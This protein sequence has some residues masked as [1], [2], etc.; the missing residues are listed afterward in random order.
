[1]HRWICVLSIAGLTSVASAAP[2]LNVDDTSWSMVG[3]IH[4]SDASSP[5]LTKF[6]ITLNADGTFAYTIVDDEGQTLTFGGFWT[7]KKNKL[8]LTFDGP[9]RSAF[10]DS[11]AL[12]FSAV[13]FSVD[14]DIEKWVIYCSLRGPQEAPTMKFKYRFRSRYVFKG[15]GSKKRSFGFRF[16]ILG[17]GTPMPVPPAP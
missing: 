6:T 4:Y 10:E 8:T 12:S 15:R 5:D 14:F 7:Q 11:M 2:T 1:M 3:R 13:G 16:S 17:D 9:S